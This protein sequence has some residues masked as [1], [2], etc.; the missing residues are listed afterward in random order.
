M[1]PAVV[2]LLALFAAC[3][4][5]SAEATN[6]VQKV[7][8]LLADL[9]AKI[10]KEGEAAQKVFDEFSEWC[11]DRSRELHFEIKTGKAEVAE[12]K[13]SID[14]SAA[15]MAA[16]G[17]KIEELAGGIAKADADLKNATAIREKEAADFAS[18]EKELLEV[19]SMLDRAVGILEKEMKKGGAAMLQFSKARGVMQALD[20]LVQAAV[21]NSA[22]V[23]RLKTALLQGARSAETME[24]ASDMSEREAQDQAAMGAPDAEVYEGHSQGIIETLEDLLEKAEAQLGDARKAETAALHGYEQ[25]KQSLEDEIKYTGQDKAEAEAGLA[26]STELKAGAEGDL[27]TTSKDLAEDTKELQ[28]L[29]HDCQA[30][31]GDFEEETKSR[32]LELKALAEALKV[33]KEMTAGAEDITY[34]LAQTSFLQIQG[35]THHPAGSQAVE[36]VKRL[37]KKQHSAALAQLASSM[38]AAIRLGRA[39]EDPFAKVRGLIEELLARLA[40]EAAS[41]ASHKAFCD[42]EMA[43]ATAKKE[44]KAAEVAKLSAQI[45]KAS[46]KSAKL[47]E[48]VAV[49]QNEL[50][51]LAA[52]QAE[53]DKLRKSE[54]DVYAA[55]K[56]ELEAGIKGVELA[57]KV[58]RDYLDKEDKAHKAAEGAESSIIGILEVVQ[59]DFSQGLAE[60]IAAE[61]T[62]QSAYEQQ[63]KEN[64][65]ARVMKEQSVKYST[66]EF[67]G[68]DKAVAE[69]TSDKESTQAELD[70]ARDALAK[71]TDMCVA[72]PESYEERK[73]RREAEI[74]GL[75]Q[76][77]EI[78]EGETVF[79]EGGQ[80]R[81]FRGR[82][83]LA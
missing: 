1:Q 44:D 5:A 73:G 15:N 50:A 4:A 27:S 35:R 10:I 9:Q 79:L 49:L 69:L 11:E 60:M 20:V 12:L 21:F 78:L 23:S 13:A 68:L 48:E 7:L 57:L 36:F 61:S 24:A 71:L 45:D 80:R 53:L 18:E 26:K 52:S 67:V 46:T 2:V 31:A 76:A 54:H 55:N 56:P 38:A 14:Q 22:D 66:K 32:G 72:K 41:E 82:R 63:T 83:G 64:E 42:K 47:K 19:I 30:K 40:K 33:V 51:Q 65:V 29:H 43:E 59:A 34:G 75:K 37:A 39:G 17:D 25:L 81:A 70:A 28:E 58:I 74:A 62:A 3:P 16:A 77:L 6:P 8:A